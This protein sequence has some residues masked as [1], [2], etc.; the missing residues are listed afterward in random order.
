MQPP[1]RIYEKA[2]REEAQR[3][4]AELKSASAVGKKMNIPRGT[5]AGWIKNSP[6][7]VPTVS[8]PIRIASK[9]SDK[10]TPP[11]LQSISNILLEIGKLLTEWEKSKKKDQSPSKAK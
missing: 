8:V 6:L 5:I 3:L 7:N 10:E 1:G 4:F 2:D 11:V 9:R